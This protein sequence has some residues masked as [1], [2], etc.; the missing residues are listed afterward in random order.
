MNAKMK[1]FGTALALF[2]VGAMSIAQEAE[3]RTPRPR[4]SSVTAPV[5]PSGLYGQQLGVATRTKLTEELKELRLQMAV[6]NRAAKELE[7]ADDGSG[8]SAIIQNLVKLKV[9]V[10]LAESLPLVART[11]EDYRWDIWLLIDAKDAEASRLKQ[12]SE[13]TQQR[14]DRLVEAI[15]N[16]E[17][18]GV[19]DVR[20]NSLKR[21]LDQRLTQ[22][23]AQKLDAE[24]SAKISATLR[25]EVE[26][27][28]T[29]DEL[30][31]GIAREKGVY[32]E[33]LLEGIEREAAVAAPEVI[34]E[35]I[36]EINEM[37]QLI[38]GSEKE[39]GK[40]PQVKRSSDP[41]DQIPSVADEVEAF[42]ETVRIRNPE[43]V[44]SLLDRARDARQKKD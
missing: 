15:L 17:E 44:E 14:C 11:I 3:P 1:M 32:A 43:R 26:R 37:I 20:I 42:A 24:E 9:L 23:D 4:E 31:D 41:N 40:R 28:T 10:K 5:R 25:D 22:C 18:N 2:A 12:R 34:A 35:G 39:D 27:L 8:R 7:K 21:E 16:A 30:L 13:S 6:M 29:L 19:S 36:N 38:S 33:R